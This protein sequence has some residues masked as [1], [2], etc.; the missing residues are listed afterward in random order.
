MSLDLDARLLALGEA[1]QVA[2]GRLEPEGVAAG[3]R[4]IEKA[5][6]RLGLGIQSTVVALAGPTGA[7]K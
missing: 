1:V 3:R 5:G 4:V 7:G 2:D 6:A